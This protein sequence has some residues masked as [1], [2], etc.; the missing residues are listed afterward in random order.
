[1]VCGV[2]ILKLTV[3]SVMREVFG[4]KIEN[5]TAIA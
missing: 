1:M 4:F 3:T 5:N 2:E